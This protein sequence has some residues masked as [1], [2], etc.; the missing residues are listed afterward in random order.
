MVIAPE[1][2]LRMSFPMIASCVPEADEEIMILLLPVAFEH[3]EQLVTPD[4]DAVVPFE[5]Y[6]EFAAADTRMPLAYIVYQTDDHILRYTR[7]AL[8]A[9]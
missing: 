9:L 7:L 5:H 6:L 3:I 1:T 2:A 4:L 8:T